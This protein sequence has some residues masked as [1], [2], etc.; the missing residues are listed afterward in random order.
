MDVAVAVAGVYS[1]RAGSVSSVMF[2][3]FLSSNPFSLCNC[4]NF[5]VFLVIL[6]LLFFRSDCCLHFAVECL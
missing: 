1:T 2:F 3:L 6:V 4:C 5:V